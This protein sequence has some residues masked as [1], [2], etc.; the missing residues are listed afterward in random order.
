M[1]MKIKLSL[2]CI[3]ILFIATQTFAQFGFNTTGSAPDNSAM[4]DIVS[5][6]KGLL[7][8]RMTSTQRIAISSP[9]IGL[10]VFDTT[11]NLF[12]FYNGT[13][14]IALSTASSV[15]DNLGN[16]TATQNINLGTNFISIDGSSKGI[17]VN[18][19]GSASVKT[20][21]SNSPSFIVQSGNTPA[22]R[23]YQEQ[24]G[25]YPSYSWD[26]GA[27]ETVFFLK[28]VSN[29]SKLP[30]RVYS[31]QNTDRLVLR[32]NNVGIG[33]SNPSEALEVSGKTKTTNFQLTNGATNSYILQSDA[34]GNG[35]WVNS[36]SLNNG[37]W[38]TSGNDQ[39]SALSGHVGIGTSTP[40]E[41]LQVVGNINI[42]SG[43]LSFSDNYASI[44]I[45]GTAGLVNT[46]NYNVFVGNES[47]TNNTTGVYNTFLGNFTGKNNTTASHNTS[48]G[49]GASENNTTGNGN[50]AFGFYAL[51]K[52]TTGRENVAIGYAALEKNTT[53]DF[54]IANGF[55]SLN[56]N[57]TGLGNSALGY[58]SLENNTTSNYNTAMGFQT[59]NQ[60]LDGEENTAIGTFALQANIDGSYNTS[61][62]LNSMKQ[63][64]IGDDNVA[65]GYESGYGNKEGEANTYI[66]YQSGYLSS[67]GSHNVFIGHKAGYNETGSNK[68]YIAN[69]ATPL[70]Y[71][72]FANKNVGI[73]T[74]TLPTE[75]NL[76]IEGNSNSEGGQIQLNSAIGQST[77]YFLDNY[78]NSFRIISGINTGSSDTRLLINSSGNIGIGN[79]SPS[80]KLD[81]A[82]TGA[83]NANVRS[84]N[85]VATITVES[86]NQNDATFYI[87]RYDGTNSLKRWAI[88]KA[89]SN[90]T[91]SNTGGDFVLNRFNDAGDYLGQP[92]LINRN[93]GTMTIGNE[94]TS[95][96]ENTLKL[97]GSFAVKRTTYSTNSTIAG[98]DYIVAVTTTSVITLTLPTASGISGREY[99]IK[100]EASTASIT[101]NTTSSQTIDGATTK[102]ISSG[103][104]VLRVYSNGINWFTF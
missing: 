20:N 90:E 88:G 2:I 62:G 82:G 72:D 76:V 46:G 6:T 54:N 93:S 69:S 56:K 17:I 27:N 10:F 96:T 86:P 30:L 73:G 104:G 87:N 43:R 32:N 12:Y 68:L 80:S 36:T 67:N 52:N 4:V 9:A 24:S 11:L 58:K 19:D 75:S 39:F 7:T 85:N 50:S 51:N 53:A 47:G 41:K 49:F 59:L 48:V 5:T 89:N 63:N 14:W 21:G 77:A 23:L 26:L 64:T 44:I 22:Y 55:Y 31:G 45:G 60:N 94:G 3:L 34:N 29:S 71:G 103:Y 79:T 40:T 100:S 25:I 37:N 28:D 98:N 13:A 15:G 97:N 16:H 8:P 57:T 81:V 74:N 33:V 65:I 91:G 61:I 95:T 78:N 92:M 66:G 101:V 99:I 102:T 38:T 18:S 42:K 1:I 83:I 35:S 70:I 84:T